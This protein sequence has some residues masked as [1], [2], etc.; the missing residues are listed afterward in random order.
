MGPSTADE[1]VPDAEGARP[2][3][4]RLR[5]NP[6][7]AASLC[8]VPGLGQLYNRQPGKAA[9]FLLATLFTL[10]SSVA[11]IMAGERIGH[12]L[13]ERRQFTA[14]L[15]LSFGS[16]FVFLALFCLGLAFWASS[17]VDARRSAIDRDAPG[18][19]WLLRL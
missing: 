13:L 14:F 19:W 8:V 6:Q 7:V 11:L 16:I 3:L 2:L 1:P 5:G 15:L 10:G 12:T 17:V 4:E 18:R 9:F